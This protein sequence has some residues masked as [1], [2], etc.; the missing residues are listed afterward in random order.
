MQ[1]S[2]VKL[3]PAFTIIELLIAT[4]IVAILVGVSTTDFRSAQARSR[5][6]NKQ[7][8]AGDYSSAMELYKA[9]R[10]T[11]LVFDSKKGTCAPTVDSTL[12]GTN[13]YALFDTAVADAAACTGYLGSPN[14]AAG[15]GQGRMTRRGGNN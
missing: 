8:S 6:A 15:G 1:R 2:L 11:Y 10:G 9:V 4:T 5:N 12:I 13:N 3:V 7:Q 14:H